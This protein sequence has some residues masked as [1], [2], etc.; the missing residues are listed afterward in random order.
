VDTIRIRVAAIVLRGNTILLV[1]HAKDGR[2]YWMLPG[3]GV[4]FGES[5]SQALERE[6]E[7]ETSLRIRANRLV[8]ANDSIAPDGARHIVNLYFTAEDLGGIPCIGA[9]PRVV[10]VVFRP[11]TDLPALPFFPDIAP[12]LVAAIETGFPNRAEY[13]GN[14]WKP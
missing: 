12:V 6:V 14:L 11:W 4:D 10:E 3:G 2:S 1:K 9:D 5:L 7:E 8:L 13:L